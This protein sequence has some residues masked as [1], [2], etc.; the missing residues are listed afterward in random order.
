AVTPRDRAPSLG[1]DPGVVAEGV[2]AL[3]PRAEPARGDHALQLAVGRPPRREVEVEILEGDPPEIPLAAQV[4]GAV[5]VDDRIARDPRVQSK[6]QA[7]AGR[8]VSGNE[9]LRPTLADWPRGENVEGVEQALDGQGR[10]ARRC[11][12]RPRQERES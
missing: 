8:R 6:L 3:S 5:E 2:V 1:Q 7:A 10:R 9:L 12:R 4:A 11:V